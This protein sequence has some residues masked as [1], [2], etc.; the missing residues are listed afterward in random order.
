MADYRMLPCMP[1][2]A[3][4]GVNG[5]TGLN[6]ERPRAAACD[7]VRF[8]LLFPAH[9]GLRRIA[10]SGLGGWSSHTASERSLVLVP[11]FMKVCIIW[12]F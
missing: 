4:L 3:T 10:A 11:P 5:A 7:K 2:Y 12:W 9:W 8:F 1:C 6:E